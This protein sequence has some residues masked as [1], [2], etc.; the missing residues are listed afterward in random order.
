M[1]S[2]SIQEHIVTRKLLWVGPLVIV[3]AILVNL[4]IRSLAVSF[5]GVPNTFQLLQPASIITSTIV[6]LLL[7]ILVL[8]LVKRFSHRPIRTYRV[9]GL[10]ALLV[11]LL[12]PVMVL[13]GLMPAPGMNISIF[14]TMILMHIVTA[15]IAIGLLTTLTREK[16]M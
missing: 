3:L 11:S 9:V 5:F 14:W 4:I 15:A 8:M 2:A 1:A 16:A 6:F 12:S 7:A 13:A 10:I